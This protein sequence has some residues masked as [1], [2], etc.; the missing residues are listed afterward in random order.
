MRKAC[1]GLLTAIMLCGCAQ[2]QQRAPKAI[3]DTEPYVTQQIDAVLAQ[4]GQG[5]LERDQLTDNARAGISAAR[6]QQMGAAVS[7]CGARPT[8]ELL[9]RTTKGEDRQY[10][11]R[12]LCGSTPLL[13]EIDFNKGAR[14][15]HLSVRP[16]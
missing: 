5:T 7:S 3:P 8:L 13:V 2:A 10:L 12:A 16:E 14:I 1:V 9:A 15:N 4:L 11:Y 6:M